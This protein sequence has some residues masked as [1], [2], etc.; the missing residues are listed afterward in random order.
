MTSILSQ[1]SRNIKYLIACILFAGGV[2]AVI[3]GAFPSRY[4]T[5]DL[6][7]I[8]LILVGIIS[9]I[10]ALLIIKF[11]IIP[12]D[13]IEKAEKDEKATA[14]IRNVFHEA[15]YS[16]EET[17]ARTQI[18]VR[19]LKEGS[20]GGNKTWREFGPTKLATVIQAANDLRD[21]R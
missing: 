20:K 18:A 14:R 8:L 11:Q 15:G 4:S 21:K 12:M 1:I 10:I 17:E 7:D 6:D 13:K 9:I 3:N 5:F 16:Q 19:L 2:F